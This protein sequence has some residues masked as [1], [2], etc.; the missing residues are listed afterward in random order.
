MACIGR[1][2]EVFSFGSSQE[3]DDVFHGLVRA[4]QPG[5]VLGIALEAMVLVGLGL[6]LRLVDA[7]NRNVKADPVDGQHHQGKKNL[8]AQLG[9]AEDV[10]QRFEHKS[11]A[12]AKPVSFSALNCRDAGLDRRRAIA[13]LFH[14]SDGD[15]R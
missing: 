10:D 3:D 14:N 1:D 2:V 7:G 4:D 13:L 5:F 9:D 11:Q 15:C 12:R 8:V 6:H